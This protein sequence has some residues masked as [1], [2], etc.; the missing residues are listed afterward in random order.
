MRLVSAEIAVTVAYAWQQQGVPGEL[1]NRHLISS[2]YYSKQSSHSSCLH[3]SQGAQKM[4]RIADVKIDAPP[5]R[6]AKEPNSARKNSELPET[7]VPGEFIVTWSKDQFL[8]RKL[9]SLILPCY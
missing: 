5:A 3:H 4:A 7:A 2:C 6:P 9:N 1:V 8:R